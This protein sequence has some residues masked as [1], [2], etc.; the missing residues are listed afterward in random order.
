M[1][2][3]RPPEGVIPDMGSSDGPASGQQE[4]AAWDGRFGCGCCHPPFI[5]DQLGDPERC[6]LRPGNVRSA[7]GWGSALKPV[8]AR[9]RKRGLDPCFRGDAALAKPELGEPLEAQGIGYAVRLP[10][11]RSFKSRSA[12]CRAGLSDVRLRSRGC[13]APASP[14]RPGAGPSPGAWWPLRGVLP[15]SAARLGST[16]S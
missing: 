1:R 13:S 9:Y 16:A 2:R 15:A 4:G 12:T 8:I 3:H 6:A 11:T 10:P 5:F 14:A 7:E